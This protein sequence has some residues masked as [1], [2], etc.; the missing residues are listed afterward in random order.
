M[1]PG[2]RHAFIVY[3][4][5]SGRPVHE[6]LFPALRN[7][8]HDYAHNFQ[9]M[10]HDP[11][12]LEA[13]L[14]ARERMLRELHAGLSDNARQFLLSLMRASPDWALMDVPHLAELPA[15]RWKLQNLVRLQKTNP[16][17]FAEQAETLA[18]RLA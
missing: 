8:E 6:V 15:V 18:A 7:I 4:V 2:I 9:G 11:V 5:S 10:T 1:T 3:L 12:P 14:A 17:K 13:L 16:R